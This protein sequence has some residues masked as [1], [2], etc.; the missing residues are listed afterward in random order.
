[1]GYTWT[2][3]QVKRVSV[4]RASGEATPAMQQLEATGTNVEALAAAASDQLRATFIDEARV[5]AVEI[6][7]LDVVIEWQDD[8]REDFGEPDSDDQLS[9]G[10]AVARWRPQRPVILRG[11]DG[12]GQIVQ[13]TGY[14]TDAGKVHYRHAREANDDDPEDQIEEY[15]GKRIKVLST[16]DYVLGGWD[17]GERLWVFTP[18]TEA[19]E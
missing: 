14:P 13:T 3:E 11:G 5:H 12:E 19:S 9:L 15:A 16:T 18:V 10:R 7:P 4:L 17:E 8:E 1:M 2:V 6:S